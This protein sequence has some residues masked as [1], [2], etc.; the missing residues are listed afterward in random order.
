V[1]LTLFTSL[2]TCAVIFYLQKQKERM[3]N[4]ANNHCTLTNYEIQISNNP[5]LLRFKEAQAQVAKENLAFNPCRQL[6]D[7]E[8]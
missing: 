3:N 8:V 2:L 4:I 6:V 5:Q 1:A 7:I